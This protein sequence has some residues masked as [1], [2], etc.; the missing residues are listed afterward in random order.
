MFLA[1]NVST[2]L[3]AFTKPNFGIVDYVVFAV[4]LCLSSAVGI[5]FSC[6]G[7]NTTGEYFFGDRQM[8]A[9]QMG[10]STGVSFMSALSLV[11]LPAE[12]YNNG[13]SYMFTIIPCIVLK[14]TA[15]AV[16]TVVIHPLKIKNFSE[17]FERRFKMKLVSKA[18]SIIMLACIFHYMGTCMFG[19]VTAINSATDG[20]IGPITALVISCSVGVFYTSIGGLKAVVWSDV[21]QFSFMLLGVVVV[22]I[23][24]LVDAPRGLSSILETNTEYRRFDIPSLSFDPTIRHSLW[25]VTIGG[26]VI[27]LIWCTQPAVI[28]RLV[29]LKTKRECYIMSAISCVIDF[30]FT[31]ISS[32]IGINL[33][34][35]YAGRGCDVFAA[36]WIEKNDI[37]TYYIRDRLSAP[38]FQGLFIVA[39]NAGSLSSLSSGLNSAS[40]IIWNDLL[41]PC[42]RRQPSERKATLIC[43]IVVVIFGA[44]AMTWSYTLI[45]FGGMIL[46]VVISLDA[47]M[48]GA[49]FTLFLYAIMFRYTNSAGAIAGI[50]LS[51]GFTLW[52]GVASLL[53]GKSHVEKLPTT[54]DNCSFIDISNASTGVSP[55]ALLN[56]TTSVD[57]IYSVSYLWLSSICILVFLVVSLLIT[58]CTQKEAADPTLLFPAC[59][60]GYFGKC[61]RDS[62]NYRSEEEDEEENNELESF[63]EIKP[64]E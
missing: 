20:Q 30:S 11:G 43:K 55:A 1:G 24:S 41:C 46:Q 40:S 34:G 45:S 7:Q 17:Y 53:Y 23:K 14:F 5:F 59:R 47:S 2:A 27:R 44:L 60:P 57:S 56:E 61:C 49:Y 39:L 22:M 35:Y 62:C 29:S 38:G 31:A 9:V 3:V 13:W 19:A 21:L 12:M 32:I 33:F 54:T 8:S 16:T 18:T 15:L 10:I 51:F 6:R 64:E 63:H 50:L 37:I 42:F 52:L 26:A 25:S 36:G 58:A 4:F 48:F 28:Q